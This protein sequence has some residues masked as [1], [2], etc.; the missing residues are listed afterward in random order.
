MGDDRPAVYREGD[1]WIIRASALGGCMRSLVAA[2]RGVEP[3]MTPEWLQVKF[4]QG[5]NGEREVAGWYFRQHPSAVPMELGPFSDAMVPEFQL[6]DNQWEFNLRVASNIIIRGHF[7]DIAIYESDDG[8]NAQFVGVEYKLLAPS[9][10]AKATGSA[11]LDVIPQYP[12]QMGAYMAI[13]GWPFD[14]VC[15]Q[16]DEDGKPIFDEDHTHVVRINADYPPHSLQDIRE[17]A[18]EIVDWIENKDYGDYPACPE[19]K[20]YPCPY[21]I[22]HEDD[23]IPELEG[24]DAELMRGVLKNRAAAKQSIEDMKKIVEEADATIKR[25]LAD[26]KTVLVDGTRVTW[27]HTETPEK[28]ITPKPY[29]KKASVSEYPK[30]T[31]PKGK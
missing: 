5:H 4:D 1:D 18:V 7:D 10:Y 31:P 14:W 13:T 28:W 25:T 2:G 26:R 15:V 24:V 9:T 12:W 17:R 30:I 22:L 21:F 8:M 19:P 3:Q 16:K 29:M 23:E 27:V 6:V 11:H 20:Q